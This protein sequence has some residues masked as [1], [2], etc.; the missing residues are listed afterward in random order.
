MLGTFN[1][2]T[3]LDTFMVRF[4]TCS[5]NFNWSENE[6]VFYMMNALTGS[7]EAIVKEVGSEGTLE[8]I[9]KLLQSRFGNR[10]K[11]EKFRN[12]LKNRRRGPDESLQDFYLDLCR[13]RAY[14]YDNDSEEKF[15][16]V[17]FRN[18]FV[19]AL[20]DRELRRAILMQEPAHHGSCL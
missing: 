4:R 6:K 9:M 19:D 11:Q 17:F 20:G 8:E 7:A 15:P 10:Y 1:G 18:M 16:E 5:R 2:R 13:L 3:D 14:A 12:E